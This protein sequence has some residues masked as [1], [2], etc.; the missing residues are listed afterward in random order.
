MAGPVQCVCGKP[1]RVPADYQG[2]RVRC[3]ACQTLCPVTGS[4]P[5][6][7]A[8]R[9]GV[10]GVS[11]S[12]EA[13]PTEKRPRPLCLVCGGKRKVKVFRVWTA[14][15]GGN[16]EVQDANGDVVPAPSYRD[17]VEHE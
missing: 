2:C 4:G 9:Y 15:F 5:G 17:V 7:D 10:E 8:A 6:E 3:P 11:P 14:A 16:V 1:I 13:A 12:G